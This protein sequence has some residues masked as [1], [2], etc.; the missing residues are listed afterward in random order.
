MKKL[1]NPPEEY[2][3]AYASISELYN[4]YLTLTNLVIS[5]TG[6]LQTFSADFNS[7]DNDTLNCYNA[8]EVYLE[9]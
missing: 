6:S 5:P 4:A 9:D 7:A 1:K 8:M 2:K 3:D